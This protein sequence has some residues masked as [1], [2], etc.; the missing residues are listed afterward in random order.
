MSLCW[1]WCC[2]LE[3]AC[4]DETFELEEMA[5]MLLDT[6]CSVRERG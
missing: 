2:K 6:A 1:S 4:V 5:R 3:K